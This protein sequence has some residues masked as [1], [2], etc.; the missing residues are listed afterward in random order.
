MAGHACD[1]DEIQAIAKRHNLHVIED[2]AHA[3]GGE[4]KG[5]KIG[6]IS[7]LTCFSFYPI[8]NMTTI[9]GGVVTTDN[10]LWAENMRIN[11]LHGV[12][13]DA[14]KRYS[15]QGEGHHEVVFP[16]F[17]YNMSDVQ[18]SLGL[19]QLLKLDGFI[20]QREHIVHQYNEAFS[21]FEEIVLLKNSENIRH[22]HHLYIIMLDIE[23]LRISRDDFVKALRKEN[24]GTGIHFRSLHIQPY[25]KERFKFKESDLPNA[26]YISDRILSLPLYP[27][28][29]QYDADTV[30]KAVKKLINYYK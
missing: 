25:Y 30:I 29:S 17:K 15:K 24:I 20:V 1:M 27:K 5:R 12:S 19:H 8:K 10:S 16:G 7:D 14:W 3:I 6:S 23:K 2:A 11:S 22:A 9:E 18:A 4:H 28:M 21:N 13:T 26:N